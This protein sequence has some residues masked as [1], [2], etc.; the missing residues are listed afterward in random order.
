MALRSTA[1][2]SGLQPE[3][4]VR[5]T[6]RYPCA[7]FLKES[8][9]EPSSGLVSQEGVKGD[10]RYI[11]FQIAVCELQTVDL[12][13]LKQE[14]TK[15]AFFINVYNLLARHGIIE[16]SCLV[17]AHRADVSFFSPLCLPPYRTLSLC[18]LSIYP[19]SVVGKKEEAYTGHSSLIHSLGPDIHSGAH[20]SLS[21]Y[22]S[23]HTGACD[24]PNTHRETR[25]PP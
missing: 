10:P 25:R 11:L 20:A 5:H 18:R 1:D 12:L 13:S 22:S 7:L 17:G 4:E 8:H 24:L 23:V 2:Q 16:V 9:T 15:K 19:E 6:R 14:H 3:T 21:A